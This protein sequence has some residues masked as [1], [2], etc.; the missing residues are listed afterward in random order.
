MNARSFASKESEKAYRTYVLK[1]IEKRLIEKYFTLPG[2]KILDLGCG[3]GRTTRPLKDMGFDVIG[4]EI[5]PGMVRGAKNDNPD[6]D[7]RLMSATDL[8]FPDAEFDYL[9][10]SF[11]GIDY[12]YPAERRMRALKEAY[13]VLKPG[14]IFI[15]SSHNKATMF[16]RASFT[17]IKSLARNIINGRIL[18]RYTISSHRE[19]DLITYAEM[20]FFQ[21]IKFRKAGFNLLE[22]DG[23]YN[24]AWLSI[25]LFEG[26][27]YYVLKKI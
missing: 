19:G 24:H 23:K 1:E 14:G 22:T 5:V 27:P 12:I 7:F 13:R 18:T 15:L 26:W 17:N 9:L 2:A 8:H 20:P 25:N 10:F 16:T 6:I 4:T 21:K 11:N 3:Y